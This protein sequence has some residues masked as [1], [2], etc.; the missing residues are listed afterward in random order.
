MTYYKSIFSSEFASWIVSLIRHTNSTSLVINSDLDPCQRMYQIAIF[1][2]WEFFFF[3]FKAFYD[4]APSNTLKQKLQLNHCHHPE[5]WK[6]ADRSVI[7]SPPNSQHILKTMG[8]TINIGLVFCLL[9]KAQSTL[10]QA[11]YQ[12]R[13]VYM[14]FSTGL[15]S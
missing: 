12:A 3:L 15:I 9:M 10:Q 6:P 2:S 7:L 5:R 14:H 4:P 1:K 11:V 8:T 13:E